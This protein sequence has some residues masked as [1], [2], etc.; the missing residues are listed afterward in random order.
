MTV[1]LSFFGVPSISLDGAVQPLPFERRTQLLAHLALRRGWV[2]RDEL[3]A[4]L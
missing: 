4:L 3:A 1:R 2:T